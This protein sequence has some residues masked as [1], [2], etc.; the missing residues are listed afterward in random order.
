MTHSEVLARLQDI[1]DDVF[2]EKVTVAPELTANDV[3]E[4]DSL[5]HISFIVAVEQAF[6]VRF[7]VGE[8]EAA[9]NVGE[10]A[11]LIERHVNSA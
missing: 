8:V 11:A 4:W 3:D 6:Q 7:R 9:R 2:L 10:L 1:F 5:V